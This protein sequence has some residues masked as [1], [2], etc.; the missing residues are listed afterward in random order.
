MLIL[1]GFTEKFGFRELCKKP[2]YRGTNRLKGMGREEG[3]FQNF[4][5]YEGLRKKERGLVFLR[6][7]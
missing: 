7:G 1:W 6:V 4:L 5:I 2:K 3:S